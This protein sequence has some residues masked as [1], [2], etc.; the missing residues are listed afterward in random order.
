VSHP[1]GNTCG[2]D[3]NNCGP[4]PDCP[5][6]GSP[7]FEDEDEARECAGRPRRIARLRFG[8]IIEV[9]LIDAARYKAATGHDAVDDD[10]ERAN[11][12][13]HGKIG[14]FNCGWCHE[15]NLPHTDHLPHETPEAKS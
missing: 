3:C 6:H 11:C 4:D 8:E 9:E 10:L 1:S 5:E 2:H 14:H 15:H 7:S 12:P 13:N